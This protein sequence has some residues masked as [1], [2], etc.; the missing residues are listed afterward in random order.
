LITTAPTFGLLLFFHILMRIFNSF[1]HPL[2]I[3]L[4]AKT[5]AR[6]DIDRA[7]GVQSGSGNL[8]VLAAFLTTGFLAQAYGW[9]RPLLAWAAAGL[10][11][12]G[13]SFLA[14]RG[15]STR[16]RGAELPKASRWLET[17]GRIRDFIP[18]FIYG[19]AGWGVV[20]YFAP[21]LFNHKFKVPLGRTGIYLALWIG[22]GTA[23]TYL[24]GWLCR[25]LGRKR[26]TML[27]MGGSALTL[28]LIGL[29]PRSGPALAGLVLYGVFLFLIY[30]AMQ[31]FVGTR[32]PDRD[33]ALAFS[34]VSN[35]Q[36]FSGALIVLL[37]GFLSDLIGIHAPF[38]LMAV[39]GAIL[40]AFYARRAPKDR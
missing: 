2:G 29:A 32:V 22:V 34:L 18:G 36:V 13:L 3:S 35:I 19:G 6:G 27:S 8:G 21:S 23:V 12:G 20:I 39:L 17:A 40:A 15:V 10:L 28:A 5:H 16:V 4:V 25:R 30:P 24:F 37:S 11:L 1:Y 7:M 26:L 14:V 9:R 33:Q 38:L 31:A